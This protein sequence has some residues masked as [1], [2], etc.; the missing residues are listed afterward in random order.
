MKL[1]EI[2]KLSFRFGLF[3]FVKEMRLIVST[4]L[5]FFIHIGSIAQTKISIYDERGQVLPGAQINYKLSGNDKSYFQITDNSGNAEIPVL[6]GEN[7]LPIIIE[8]DYLGFEKLLDTIQAGKS[9]KIHLKPEEVLLNQL[10]ITGQYKEGNPEKSVHKIKILEMEELKNRGVVNLKDALE[11]ETNMRI[12]RDNVLGSSISIQGMSG[13]NVKIMI[14]GVPVIGRQDGNIDLNQINLNNVDRI[15]IVEGPLSV[16][17][18]TNA[19]AGTINII[20][21]K[22]Q[23]EEINIGLNTYYESVGQYNLDGQL[24]YSKK[25]HRISVSGGRNFFDGWSADED[26][27]FIPES[28]PADS[29]RFLQWKPK[30]QYF[31]NFQYSIKSK[32]GSYRLFADVFR[33]DITSK[34]IPRA[35]YYLTAFDQYF[36][37]NRYMLGFD[38]NE[39]AGENIY[40]SILASYNFYSRSR[41]TYFKDLTDLSEELTENPEDHDTT[42]FDS[43]MSRGSLRFVPE[44]SKLNWEVGYDLNHEIA[45]GKRIEDGIKSIGDYAIF[46]TAE[47]TIASKLIVKPG[48]RYAY[49]TAYSSPLI[50]SINFRLGSKSIIY[51]LSY[52]KGFRSPSLKELYFE[53]VDINHDVFGNQELLAETSD[54]IQFDATYQLR[55]KQGV[56]EIEAGLFFNEINNMI[57]LSQINQSQQYTYMNIGKFR[58]KGLDFNLNQS[59]NRWKFVFGF[60]LTGRQSEIENVETQSAMY[61]SPEYKGTVLYELKKIGGNLSAYYKYNGSLPIYYNDDLGNTEIATAAAYEMVDLSATKYFLKKSLNL[62]VGVKNLLDVQNIISSGSASGNHTSDAGS[63]P[64]SWGRTFFASIKWTINSK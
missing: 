55:G 38:V 54:N 12:S 60:V 17:Y 11:F 52:A 26:V 64:V 61:Y 32:E 41:N 63:I 33:E 44:N 7:E 36:I 30:E 48:L 15:E 6:P 45:E 43:Y 20:T 49:N 29:S 10:V 53:F 59:L 47:W 57:A 18:G 23:A 56:T 3:S 34:G 8:I 2:A 25:K 4:S 51:R 27:K 16:N 14:D 31:L 21:K 5:L 9:I 58:S 13:E 40:W 1:S 35:P 46:T 39:K 37:T 22:D 24:S 42:G 62:T 50:P 28:Q 19:L